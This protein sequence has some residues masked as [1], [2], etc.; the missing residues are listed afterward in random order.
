MGQAVVPFE[1]S[2]PDGRSDR[3]VIYDLASVAEV[4]TLFSY[5]ELVA[6]LAE[7]LEEKPDR[8][9]VYPAVAAANRSLLKRD[10]RYLRCVRR[11]G[12][13]LIRSDE[14]LEVALQKQDYATS[15]LKRGVEVLRCT[16][17]EE[18]TPAAR[19][20]HEGTLMISV[21]MLN[22]MRESFRRHERMERA[23]DDLRKR[24]SQLEG[25]ESGG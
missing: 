15:Y 12:Y 20:A 4:E 23:V 24:V 18:L 10:Q 14:H 22:A 8:E 19:Q 17:L 6:A 16:R 11:R 9:R 13:R 7:G 25:Q 3:Q 2:R 1:P 5:K 21:G